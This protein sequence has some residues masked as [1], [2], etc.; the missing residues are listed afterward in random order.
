MAK[1][2]NMLPSEIISRA[3]TYD[4]LVYNSLMAWEQEQQD[5]AAGRKPVPK[6]STEQ[7]LEMIK[8]VRKQ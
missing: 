7:M 5:R 6:L 4:L 8:K 2:Y 1:Q 3:T